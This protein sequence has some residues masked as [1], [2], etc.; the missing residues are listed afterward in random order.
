MYVMRVL[1]HVTHILAVIEKEGLTYLACPA[2]VQQLARRALCSAA[3][4]YLL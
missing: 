2:V 1:E 4:S 3:V